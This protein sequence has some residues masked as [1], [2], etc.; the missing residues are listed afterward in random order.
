MVQVARNV[1]R[2]GFSFG[3]SW[4][5]VT[6]AVFL[7]IRLMPGDPAVIFADSRSLGATASYIEEL[8]AA[9]RLDQPLI[10]QFGGWL[11]GFVT[12]DWGASYV[13]GRPV[14]E[15]IMRRLPW[16]LA[17]GS[18]GLAVAV[19]CGFVLG[20]FAAARPGGVAD[21]FSRLASIGGQA[22]PAFAVALTLLWLMS[23]EF[24][25]VRPL[26]GGVAER[27]ILPVMVV[28][29]FSLGSVARLSRVA[30][31]QVT[32]QP[33]FRTAL[34]KGL[35]R[36][37]ALWRH[38]R[39]HAALTVLAALTPELA[40]VI[41]GTAITE[42]VFSIPGLSEYVVTAVSARDYAVLQAF[43]AVVAIWLLLV[44]GLAAFARR[45]LDPRLSDPGLSGGVA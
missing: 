40:W 26:S 21:R 25:L 33:Y 8:R 27:L 38:G 34:V 3:L 22:I 31:R 35:G 36:R 28:A 43:V 13:T 12:G 2:I 16:S 5:A 42:I 18:L 32:D 6:L 24:R 17:I 29:F 9:W 45:R 7:L 44:Q 30:F 37:I 1:S 14:F 41:G 20:F 4:L 23:I 10:A 11:A 39:R 15:E 19:L